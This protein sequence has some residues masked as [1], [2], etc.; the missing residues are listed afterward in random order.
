MG[1]AAVGLLYLIALLAPVLAPYDPA[2]Q[3]DLVAGRLLPASLAHPLGTDALSR[4]LLSRLLFGARL[5]LSIAAL[6]VVVAVTVGTA[7]GLAAGLAGGVVDAALMRSVDAALAIPRVFLLIVI[8][9]LWEHGGIAALVLVLGLTGWFGTSRLVRA[10]VQSLKQRD[11]VLAARALGLP[12]W[13]IAL[14]HILPNATAP[15]IVSATLGV[16]NTILI[17]A[18]LSFLGIGVRPPMPSWGNM[19][20]DGQAFLATAPWQAIVPGAAVV[21]TVM[22]FS[23]LGE[24]LRETID[25]RTW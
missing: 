19:I 11:F 12:A 13:R 1:L 18:A 14:R 8:L 3:L 7:V 15:I 6:A 23:V 24:A 16:G 22:T 5:S 17:E 25:P 20:A 10:E 2:A 21:L 4:D 9:A